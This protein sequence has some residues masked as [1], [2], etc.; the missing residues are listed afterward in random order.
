M[1]YCEIKVFT[2]LPKTVQQPAPAITV[3]TPEV[4]MEEFPPSQLATPPYQEGYAAVVASPLQRLALGINS[5][6][7]AVKISLP[8]GNSLGPEKHSCELRDFHGYFDESSTGIAD[9]VETVGK[10][11]DW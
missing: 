10:G 7:T 11:M 4:F 9:C 3:K 6:R 8:S 2:T 5:C 1:T